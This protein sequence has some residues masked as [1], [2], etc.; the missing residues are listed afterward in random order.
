MYTGCLC[1]CICECTCVYDAN[2]I[3]NFQVMLQSSI[4]VLAENYYNMLK[5]SHTNHLISCNFHYCILQL[6]SFANMSEK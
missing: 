2:T 4:S 3:S 6:V 1:M 5:N